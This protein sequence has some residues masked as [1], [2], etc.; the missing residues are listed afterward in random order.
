MTNEPQPTQPGGQADAQAGAQSGGMQEIS[1]VV[2]SLGIGE[3][4]A[5][6]G[7]A[8]VL[9]TWLVFQVLMTEYSIGHLP[10]ALA[11]LIVFLGYRFN[12][13]HATD[14]A[15]PYRT[16]LIVLAGLLGLIGAQELVLDLRY[17]IFD[18]DATTVIGA[19]AFWAASITA[20]VGALRMAGK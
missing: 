13:Q 17:E 2:Q 5:I 11:A 20:G 18:T 10:F 4:L 3:K 8:G 9:A 14:W 12:M 6:L 15:V 1:R 19:I 16:L 7:S